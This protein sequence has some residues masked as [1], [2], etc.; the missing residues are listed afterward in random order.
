M[1]LGQSSRLPVG[2]LHAMT[3]FFVAF[4]TVYPPCQDFEN[5]LQLRNVHL[6]RRHRLAVAPVER[7]ARKLA[8]CCQERIAT[9]ARTTIHLPQATPWE[10]TAPLSSTQTQDMSPDARSVIHILQVGCPALV[11]RNQAI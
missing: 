10:R 7:A 4:F 2:R 5:L 9:S 6:H 11:L 1:R 8:R 3:F